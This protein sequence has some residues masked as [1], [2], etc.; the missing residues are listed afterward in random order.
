MFKKEITLC[1]IFAFPLVIGTFYSVSNVIM[2]HFPKFAQQTLV[3]Q[4]NEFTRYIYIIEPILTITLLQ[5]VRDVLKQR[6]DA[7]MKA[8]GLRII[9]GDINIRTV[10]TNFII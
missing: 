10:D 8:C 7:F 1:V 6:W 4:F 3:V 5:E 9:S 2:Q